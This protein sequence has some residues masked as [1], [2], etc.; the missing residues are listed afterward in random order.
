MSRI[1]DI[2]WNKARYP[3][4]YQDKSQIIK[5]IG[6]GTNNGIKKKNRFTLT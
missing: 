2:P 6:Q 3:S 4:R 5:I 1:I